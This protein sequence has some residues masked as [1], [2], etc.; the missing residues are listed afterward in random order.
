ICRT[1]RIDVQGGRRGARDRFKDVAGARSPDGELGVRRRSAEAELATAAERSE[2]QE[3][4]S[5]SRVVESDGVE[6]GRVGAA[7]KDDAVVE[8]AAGP[9]ERGERDRVAPDRER[10]RSICSARG[11]LPRAGV[12]LGTPR[13]AQRRGR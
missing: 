3:T 4:A 8:V 10:G 2:S 7:A 13:S 12:L 6:D 1:R 11:T 5:G 9:R